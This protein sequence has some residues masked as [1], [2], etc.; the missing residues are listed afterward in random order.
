MPYQQHLL[1]TIRTYVDGQF[2][3]FKERVN[4]RLGFQYREIAWDIGKVVRRPDAPR[5]KV[6][7]FNTYTAL[8]YSRWAE[9][10]HLL[11]R[12]FQHGEVVV[13]GDSNAGKT[14]MIN[15]F[16]VP[17]LRESA[18]NVYYAEIW[19]RPVDE[20]REA[21]DRGAGITMGAE[22]DIVSTC[23][24]L[25]SQGPCFF[26]IDG[27]ERLKGVSADE[28]EKFERFV[29]FC[30]DNENVYL[31]AI[32]D[33]DEF[34][35]W[36][37]PFRKLSLS[38]VF[39]VEPLGR[40]TADHAV[41]P[42]PDI[43]PLERLKELVE[44][45]RTKTGDERELREIVYALTGEGARTLRRY[46]VSQLFLETGISHDKIVSCLDLLKD[47]GIVRKQ[48]LSGTSFYVLSTRHLNEPLHE[49]LQ[50]NE[51]AEK[52]R[53]RAALRS[54]VKTGEFLQ[55]QMLS[56][57][58]RWKDRMVFSK[59]E[60]GLILASMLYRGWD[61]SDFVMKAEKETRGF[62][63]DFSVSL[64][65]HSDRETRGHVIKLLSNAKDEG[66]LNHLLAHLRNEKDPEV[67]SRIVKAIAGAGK[68]KSVVALFAA[69]I[70]S[71]DR[72]RRLEVIESIC[73]LPV[74]ASREL[75]IEAAELEKDVEII[76]QIDALLAKLESN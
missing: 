27:C 55:E 16:V 18:D 44:E 24:K 59:A 21:I 49:L 64:L 14:T 2:R 54:S 63:Y 15:S 29:R 42:D 28:K 66:A 6:F 76:D 72:D 61:Y 57:I 35:E 17:Q 74:R 48:E 50:L 33:K 60:L 37:A 13:V 23:K 68:K 52:G 22:I 5:P 8:P 41:E 67:R 70:E 47:R 69:L 32:G 46:E 7:P 38:A 36:Y 62:D 25:V 73:A 43:I 34:F 65:D 26:I 51:F 45:I 53:I 20:I 56:M 9:A 31:I 4:G 75:L 11:D 19:E 12:L 10:S 30:I 39:E 58:Q 1:E 3:Q 40:L 71:G